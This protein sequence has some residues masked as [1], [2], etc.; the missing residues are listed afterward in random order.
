MLEKQRAFPAFHEDVYDAIG[1]AVQALGGPKKVAGMLWPNKKLD[2][3]YA[4]LKNCLRDDKAEK[5]DPHETLLIGKMAKEVG[6]HAIAEFF[7]DFM[8]YESPKPYTP[9]DEMTELLRQNN[10]LTKQLIRSNEKLA[11]ASIKSV[12]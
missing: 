12:G 3:A 9:K 1:A 10:E 5:L 2:T 4:H 8:G 7:N 11:R 6:E